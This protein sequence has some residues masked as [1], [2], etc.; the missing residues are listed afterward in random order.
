MRKKTRFGG[1]FSLMSFQILV[2]ALAGRK[3]AVKQPLNSLGQ[4]FNKTRK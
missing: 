3:E 2:C 4:T 1:S